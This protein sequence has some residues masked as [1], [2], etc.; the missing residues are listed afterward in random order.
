VLETGF[1]MVIG[2]PTAKATGLLSLLVSA[3][4]EDGDSGSANGAAI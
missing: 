1:D 3:K 4:I 2:Y